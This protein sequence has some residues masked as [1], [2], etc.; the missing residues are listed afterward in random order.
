ME[1]FTSYIS[2]PGSSESIQQQLNSMT[3]QLGSREAAILWVMRHLNVD[4]KTLNENLEQTPDN[5]VSFSHAKYGK[6]APFFNMCERYNPA[7]WPQ[8]T[9][10][11]A[12]LPRRLKRLIY[13]SG[14][15]SLVANGGP[16][17]HLTEATRNHVLKAVSFF[18]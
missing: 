12:F 3:Q 4:L 9:V 11:R 13:R 6:I 15:A 10:T 17:E 8:I 14:A 5:L 16:D 7:D 1:I 18:N 2:D